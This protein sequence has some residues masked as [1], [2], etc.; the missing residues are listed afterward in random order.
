[1]PS[2]PGTPLATVAY[3]LSRPLTRSSGMP[4]GDWTKSSSSGTPHAAATTAPS[5]PPP[6][7]VRNW[8]LVTAI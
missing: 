2:E 7:A 3:Q 8:R 1:M 4:G 6:T 5:A